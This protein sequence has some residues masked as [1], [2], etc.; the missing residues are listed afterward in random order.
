MTREE[1]RAGRA[2]LRAVEKERDVCSTPCAAPFW[3]Q[4]E[5]LWSHRETNVRSA[6]IES[7]CTNRLPSMGEP[8]FAAKAPA[9]EARARLG[10]HRNRQRTTVGDLAPTVGPTGDLRTVSASCSR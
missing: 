6:S 1:I 4:C 7:G 3:R 8:R 2:N 5:T 10:D 9:R